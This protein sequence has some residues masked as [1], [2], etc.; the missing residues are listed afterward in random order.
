[1]RRLILLLLLIA[2]P[3]MGA[4]YQIADPVVVPFVVTVNNTFDDRQRPEDHGCILN[5]EKNEWEC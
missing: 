1:M 3:A 5:E 2:S 4:E